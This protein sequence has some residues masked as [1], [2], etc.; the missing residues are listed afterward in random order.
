MKIQIMKTI[1]KFYNRCCLSRKLMKQIHILSPKCLM[2]VTCD[3]HSDEKMYELF[4]LFVFI[5]FEDK[6]E[7]RIPDII[8][9]PIFV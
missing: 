5:S 1:I 8:N 3:V 7:N 2:M 4:F 6:F 9:F